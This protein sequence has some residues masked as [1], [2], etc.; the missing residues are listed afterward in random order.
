METETFPAGWSGERQIARVSAECSPWSQGLSD[1]ARVGTDRQA[2]ADERSVSAGHQQVPRLQAPA[3]LDDWRGAAAPASCSCTICDCVS[4][5][6]VSA[7]F[8]G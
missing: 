8:A 7:C 5:G 3:V 4:S 1:D 6:R 2:G